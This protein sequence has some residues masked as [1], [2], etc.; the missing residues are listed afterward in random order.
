MLYPERLAFRTDGER[1]V[2]ELASSDLPE[3]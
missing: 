2:A 3:K 1:E